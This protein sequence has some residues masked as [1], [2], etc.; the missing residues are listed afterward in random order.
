MTGKANAEV[1]PLPIQ[2]RT[3]QNRLVAAIEDAINAR[4]AEYPLTYCDI[5]GALA[6]VT[7]HVMAQ[8]EE[9]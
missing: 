2:E 1:V 8:L 9:D 3:Y 6:C 7:S 4:A 5:L